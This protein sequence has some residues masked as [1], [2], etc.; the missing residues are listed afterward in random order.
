MSNNSADIK[1]YVTLFT[2]T[3]VPDDASNPAHYTW[4]IPQ[5]YYSNQRSSTCSVSCVGANLTTKGIHPS[6]IV[7]WEGGTTNSYEQ[8]QREVLFHPTAVG[9]GYAAGSKF[10]HTSPDTN[11]IELM[12]RPR[13]NTI[14]LAFVG[15]A[16]VR[17]AYIQT[18]CITL[19]FTYYNQEASTD[20]LMGQFTPTLK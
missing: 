12:V 14:T 6:V 9:Y 10:F 4:N 20:L 16:G 11:I 15:E 3:G 18:G 17:D 5:S 1:D 7:T 13:P 19:C 2:S 8:D